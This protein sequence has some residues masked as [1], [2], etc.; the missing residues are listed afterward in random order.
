MKAII[1]FSMFFFF[2]GFNAQEK[3]EITPIG[4]SNLSQVITLPGLNSK[5][6]YDNL[7]NYIQTNFYNPNKVEKGNIENQFISFNGEKSISNNNQ[8]KKLNYFVS[9]DIKDEKVRL[10]FN[11][12]T[13][14]I[15]Y[16]N[17][18]KEWIGTNGSLYFDKSGNI[19]KRYNADKIA[20]ET[21]L[22]SIQQDILKAAKGENNNW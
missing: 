1:V 15:P 20:K 13:E 5:Q 9:I 8:V 21:A 6:I 12:L 22:N 7:N 17:I 16:L 2:I 18:T 19:I 11:K 3:I 10:T 14:S 4:I